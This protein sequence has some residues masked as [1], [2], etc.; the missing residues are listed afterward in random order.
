MPV[1]AG[2]RPTAWAVHNIPAPEPIGKLSWRLIGWTEAGAAAAK[3]AASA[4]ARLTGRRIV[5]AL[6]LVLVLVLVA[7]PQTR[8][9]AAG[10]GLLDQRRGVQRS[11]VD[12]RSV[13]GRLVTR[14]QQGPEHDLGTG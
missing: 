4:A 3:A 6:L 13:G 12:Q 8:I 14:R 9:A 10:D 1:S 5:I 2:S 7:D 11:G